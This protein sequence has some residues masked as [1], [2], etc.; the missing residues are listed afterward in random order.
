MSVNSELMQKILHLLRPL[1]E[2]ESQRRGYLITHITKYFCLIINSKYL[3]ALFFR[4][5]Y[6]I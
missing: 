3:K 2:N 4:T 6:L 1:M 5:D